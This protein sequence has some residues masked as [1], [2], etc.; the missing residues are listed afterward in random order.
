MHNKT[1]CVAVCPRRPHVGLVVYRV[2]VFCVCIVRALVGSDYPW[3]GQCQFKM[4]LLNVSKC[5]GSLFTHFGLNGLNRMV[6]S[7]DGKVSISESL[8][9]SGAWLLIGLS[10]KKCTSTEIRVV[11]WGCELDRYVA[12]AK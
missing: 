3:R 12:R 10:T 8:Q 11:D 2:I 6:V 9:E 1:Q 7:P 4:L 5:C